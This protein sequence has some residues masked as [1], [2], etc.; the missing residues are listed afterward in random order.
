MRNYLTGHCKLSN[1]VGKQMARLPLDPMYS[2]ALI[3][4]T[5]FKCLEGM[6]I[7]VSSYSYLQCDDVQ[8]Q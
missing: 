3:V 8:E 7:D 1:P 4:S 6:L 5:E 2:K